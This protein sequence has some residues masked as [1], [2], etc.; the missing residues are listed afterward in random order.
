M[1]AFLSA[2]QRGISGLV[3]WIIIVLMLVMMVTVSLQIVFR[4]VF[5]IPLGWSEE[6][7]RFAF[8]WVSFI[9]A[10]ALMRAREH[11]NVTVFLDRFPPRL[12]AVAVFIANVGAVI[13]VYFFLVGGIALTTNEWAQLAPATEIPMGWVYLVIPVSSGLMGIWVVAQTIEAALQLRGKGGP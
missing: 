5:N 7:A 1:R 9:G 4:Y 11:I 6:M 2:V 13:C 12:Q 8:V 3:R 10:S